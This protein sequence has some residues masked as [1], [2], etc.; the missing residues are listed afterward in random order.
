MVG[1]SGEAPSPLGYPQGAPHSRTSPS[2]AV[3]SGHVTQAE[4]EGFPHHPDHERYFGNEGGGGRQGVTVPIP[5]PLP[6]TSGWDATTFA[7]ALDL[8]SRAQ[9]SNVAVPVGTRGPAVANAT[10]GD[11][12]PPNLP[13]YISPVSPG[14]WG[15]SPR[16]HP[17]TT[18]TTTTPAPLPAWQSC[19]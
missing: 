19:R 13:G 7:L 5:P 8:L 6:V 11:R 9:V 14:A 1:G 3:G 15:W 16:R 4:E 12:R 17:P 18:T 10:R 2:L